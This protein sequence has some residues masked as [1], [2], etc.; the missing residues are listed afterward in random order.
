MIK[1]AVAYAAQGLVSL[2]KNVSF[3]GD[4]DTYTNEAEAQIKLLG[5]R[6]RK[7]FRLKKLFL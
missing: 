5:D 6:S 7:R 1:A 3:L 2:L 4:G